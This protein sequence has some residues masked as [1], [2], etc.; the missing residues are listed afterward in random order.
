[1]AAKAC[2]SLASLASELASTDKQEVRIELLT[3][4]IGSERREQGV[5]V[6]SYLEYKLELELIAAKMS[7]GSNTYP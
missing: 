3:I 5:T 4:S 1:M 2:R 6:K 7:M